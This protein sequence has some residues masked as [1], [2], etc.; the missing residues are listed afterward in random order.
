MSPSYE[1]RI[2]VRLLTQTTSLGVAQCRMLGIKE[3]LGDI[4][5]LL[6]SHVEV[7]GIVEEAGIFLILVALQKI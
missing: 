7:A 6:D 3:A 1:Q 4:V 2:P 5:V